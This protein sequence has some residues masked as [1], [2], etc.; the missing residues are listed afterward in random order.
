VSCAK[1]S[2]QP[3]REAQ[4][5]AAQVAA[6]LAALFEKKKTKDQRPK[7]KAA[8]GAGCAVCGVLFCFLSV[9]LG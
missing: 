1:E 7:Q 4:Q 8:S 2:Q 5:P 6:Q 9:C 3:N